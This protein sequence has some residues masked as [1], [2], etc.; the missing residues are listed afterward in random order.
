MGALCSALR[1][2]AAFAHHQTLLRQVFVD[3]LENLARE[4]ARSPQRAAFQRGAAAGA[5]A[6]LRSMR[7]KPRITP[8][9]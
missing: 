2:D 5:D 4:L 9:A 8:L 7:T 6:R 1:R 3:G